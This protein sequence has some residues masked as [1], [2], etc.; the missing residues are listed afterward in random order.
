MMGGMCISAPYNPAVRGDQLKCKV[1]APLQISLSGSS[2]KS[3]KK[4][5][6]K[7]SATE[8]G[9]GISATITPNRDATANAH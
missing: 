6:N 1:D 5:K 9:V 3:N 2:F 4:S 8:G 7:E